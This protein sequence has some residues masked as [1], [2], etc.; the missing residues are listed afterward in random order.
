M[1]EGVENTRD[2]I[3]FRRRKKD[4]EWGRLRVEIR[5]RLKKR[6]KYKRIEKEEKIKKKNLKRIKKEREVDPEV[7]INIENLI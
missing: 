5:M 6:E 1:K 7:M 2:L 4:L 3:V